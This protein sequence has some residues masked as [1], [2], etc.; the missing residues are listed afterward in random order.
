V[1]SR[2]TFLADA[3]DPEGIRPMGGVTDRR[4]A[5]AVKGIHVATVLTVVVLAAGCGPAGPAEQAERVRLLQ[6]LDVVTVTDGQIEE[7]LAISGP[8]EPYRS[9]EVRAQLAGELVSVN[10]ER[11]TTVAAGAVL[12]RFDAATVR[13]QLLGARAAVA[14]A[15]AA[16]A[17]ASHRLESAE[18]LYAAGA[19]SRQDLRQARSAAESA[20]AQVAAAA[21]QL[22]QAGAAERSTV[23]RAP[24]G[25]IVSAR[26]VSA[27]EAVVPGQPLFRIVDTDTLELAAR[28]PVSGLGSFREGDPVVF[29]IDDASGRLLTGYVDRIEPMVDP[30]TRQVI[31]YARLPNTD[32]ALVGGLYATGTIVLRTVRGASL[33]AASVMEAPGGGRHVLVIDDGRAARREVRVLGEDRASGQVVV[34]GVEPGALVIARPGRLEGGEAVRLAGGR[35]EPEAS[36]VRP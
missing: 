3:T 25:G 20:V 14:A 15:E 6:P 34:D 19:V 24:S 27:G 31:V 29:R 8:L 2:A 18:A 17:S 36:E 21:A 7:G 12:G 16:A 1:A 4:E 26:L 10:V 9:V 13:S 28:V 30:S 22:A 5:D 33:P 23:L 35:V 32:G 11:G